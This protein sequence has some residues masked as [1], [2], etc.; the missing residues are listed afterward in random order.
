MLT[1]IDQGRHLTLTRRTWIAGA[2]AALGQGMLS[3]SV[4]AESDTIDAMVKAFV[5]NGLA[6]ALSTAVIHNGK[7]RF[8]NAGIAS[9]ETGALV[10][11]DTVYEIGSITKTFTSLLLA[12]AIVEGRASIDDPVTRFLPRGFDNLASSGR[13]VTLRHLVA[14]TSALPDNPPGVDRLLAKG[15]TYDTALELSQFAASYS[16]HEFLADL[17][18]AKLVRPPGQEPRHSNVAAHLVGLIVEK[19]FRAPYASLMTRFVERPFGMAPG[20]PMEATVSRAAFGYDA[21]ARAMPMLN[22]RADLLSGG[23]RYSSSDMARYLAKQIAGAESAIRLTQISTWTSSSRIAIG[24]NWIIS[25][26]IEGHLRFQHSGST[27]GFSSFAEFCPQKKYAVVVLAN[28]LGREKA[29]GQ[30]AEA[31]RRRT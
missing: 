5:A 14:T 28:R 9:R 4:H 8:Y 22:T 30:L 7:V 12:H 19:I 26:G 1:F 2:T 24:F 31:I 10:T 27:L 6:D 29:L 11:K 3:A 18:E 17:R 23:L 21:N 13:A 20:S 16:D 25:R 15:F